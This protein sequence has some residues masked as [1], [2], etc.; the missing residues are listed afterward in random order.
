M[1]ENMWTYLSMYGVV[2]ALFGNRTTLKP[3]V[4]DIFSIISNINGGHSNGG[5]PFG[6][7]Y[8][9]DYVATP[10]LNKEYKPHMKSN[11]IYR[12]Y[13]Y[14]DDVMFRDGIIKS[15]TPSL[16]GMVYQYIDGVQKGTIQDGHQIYQGRYVYAMTQLAKIALTED[17]K[18]FGEAQLIE[19]A[20]QFEKIA[21]TIKARRIA[22]NLD[23]GNLSSART[24]P[25]DLETV[26]TLM[27]KLEW[28]GYRYFA[29][30]PAYHHFQTFS[31]P[32]AQKYIL[33]NDL[34]NEYLTYL[35]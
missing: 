14:Y 1:K 33:D 19:Q 9:W 12:L 5:T 31:L 25:L 20:W 16:G 35:N 29:G 7:D 13:W 27:N 21:P 11:M 34:Y 6:E 23:G 17:S 24:Y 15:W 4:D 30:A 28:I 32:Q 26:R 2:D 10:G 22:A 8:I 3:Y 18:A